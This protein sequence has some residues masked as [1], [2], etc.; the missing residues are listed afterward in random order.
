MWGHG[1]MSAEHGVLVDATLALPAYTLALAGLKGL[2][3][4][5]LLHI[6]VRGPAKRPTVE[7][8]KCGAGHGM[9][10]TCLEALYVCK[11]PEEAAWW[12]ASKHCSIGIQSSMS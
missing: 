3:P 9:I 6:G 12:L 5:Y 7:W 10:T 4:E 2:P 11:Q 8:L 1:L